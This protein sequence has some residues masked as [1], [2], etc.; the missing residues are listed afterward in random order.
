MNTFNKETYDRIRDEVRHYIDQS[1][2]GR[3]SI[4]FY[5]N[6]GEGKSYLVN[7]LYDEMRDAGYKKFFTTENNEMPH[8]RM[9]TRSQ[10]SDSMV[11]TSVNPLDKCDSRFKVFDFTQ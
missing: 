5:G 3:K 7:E 1:C 4:L 9:I 6:G 8:D 2:E 11:V 10:R